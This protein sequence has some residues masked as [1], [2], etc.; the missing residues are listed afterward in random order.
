[1]D[2]NN[3]DQILTV[4]RRHKVSQAKLPDGTMIVFEPEVA[5]LP[6]AIEPTPGGWKDSTPVDLPFEPDVAHAEVP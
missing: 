4:L 5:E 1:M 6:N 2:P 3:L